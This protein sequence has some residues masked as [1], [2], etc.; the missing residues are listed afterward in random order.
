[1][2]AGLLF[3]RSRRTSVCEKTIRRAA[4][5]FH[6]SL[7]DVRVCTREDRLNPNMAELLKNAEVVFTISKGDGGCPAC[8]APL[9]GTLH[10]PVGEDGEPV[11]VLRLTGRETKGYL[12]ESE[13]RA[14]FILPDDPSEILEMLP[15]AFERLKQKFELE[16]EIPAPKDIDFQFSPEKVSEDRIPGQNQTQEQKGGLWEETWMK[17]EWWKN[18]CSTRFRH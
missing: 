11:G 13:D 7:G 3:Y 4:G 16:G 8:A 6:L 14:I 5:W 10:V 12:V 17:F 1:M 2:D 18:Y 9:F 15:A